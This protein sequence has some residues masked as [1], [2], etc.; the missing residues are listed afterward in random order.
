M[1]RQ[2]KKQF[3]T[4]KLFY[5][6]VIFLL[7]S[8]FSCKKMVTDDLP[9]IEPVPVVNA[10]LV[11][12][13]PINFHVSFA[14]LPDNKSNICKNAEVK[15][16]VDDVFAELVAFDESMQLYPT[17]TIAKAG[18]K[19]SCEVYI[20]GYDSLF[21]ETSIPQPANIYDMEYILVAGFDDE[22]RSYPAIRF[23]FDTDPDKMMYYQAVLPRGEDY[24]YYLYNPIDPVINNEG[25]DFPI[26][27]NEII[28][29]NSYRMELSFY[30]GS[31]SEWITYNP[32]VALQFKSA[33]E[34]FYKYIKQ[35]YLYKEYDKNMGDMINNILVGTM[36]TPNMYSN[37]IGGYGIFAGL[38]VTVCDTIYPPERQGDW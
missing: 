4:S 16:F 30:T 35:L 37:V 31:H 36:Y 13:K 8:I 32:A 11:N 17:N 1:R 27:S 38:S 23:T 7:A 25:T 20:P 3:I 21:A 22:G 10:L 18:K 9:F 15:L 26:F 19:Y 29:T 33:S 24:E 2:D 12:D 5:L 14:K 28:K 34:E 6:L